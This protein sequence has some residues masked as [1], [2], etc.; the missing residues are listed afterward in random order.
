MPKSHSLPAHDL[1]RIVITT[2][3]HHHDIRVLMNRD[4]FLDGNFS[5]DNHS[6]ANFDSVSCDSACECSL[7]LVMFV[8]NQARF[9]AGLIVL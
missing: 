5:F 1:T 9:I 4:T 7:L 3:T 6:V 2:I 8:H